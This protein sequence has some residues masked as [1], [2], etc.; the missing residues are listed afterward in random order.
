MSAE[1]PSSE[2][3]EIIAG[4]TVL[5][6]KVLA[7]YS[8][9]GGWTLKYRIIG[10]G[11]NLEKI[12]TDDSGTYL[13]TIAAADL[14]AIVAEAV[15]RLV[16]WVEKG[17]EKWTVYDDYCRVQPNLR[18][19]TADQ[20][21]TKAAKTLEAIEAALEGRITADLE[22]YQVNGRAVTKIPIKE[23]QELRAAYTTIVWREQNRGASFPS[24]EIRFR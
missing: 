22:S 16:G 13:V 12:A 11:I 23:L 15:C 18:T 2:P 3:L 17:A 4:D 14:A 6:H 24:H 8:I 1:I 7:D 9:A 20:L 19:A 10:T 5:W 21:K